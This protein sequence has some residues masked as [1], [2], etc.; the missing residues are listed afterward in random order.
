MS[1]GLARIRR[2]TKFRT[3]FKGEY[4]RKRFRLNIGVLSLLTGLGLIFIS[5]LKHL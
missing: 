3:G 2:R 4:K 5:L 1:I